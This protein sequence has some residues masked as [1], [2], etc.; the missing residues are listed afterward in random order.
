[1]S[2]KKKISHRPVCDVSMLKRLFAY[3]FDYYVGLLLCSFPIVLMNGILN[4]DDRMQMNIFFFKSNPISLYLSAFLSLFMGYFYY[5]H[6]PLKVWKGQTPAKRL[7]HFKIVKTD[8][9]NVD[10]LTLIKR[11]G[12]G[13]LLVEGAVISCTSVI[14]QLISYA[15]GLNFVDPWISLGILITFISCLIMVFGSKHRMIHD[16][17]SDTLVT[18]DF[19]QINES[20]GE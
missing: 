17:I 11:H 12:V 3:I 10:W 15:T 8:G 2:K 6:I 16:F 18:Q 5:I 13:M 20:E 14:R 7:F 19:Y 1:M 4:Q 9:H